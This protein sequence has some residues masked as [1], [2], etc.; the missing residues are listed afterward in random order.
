MA[1]SVSPDNPQHRASISFLF[2]TQSTPSP[3]PAS[4]RLTR[5]VRAPPYM[6]P[7]ALILPPRHPR[8][9]PCWRLPPQALLRPRRPPPPPANCFSTLPPVKRPHT[10][11]RSLPRCI[12]VHCG[13]CCRRLCSSCRCRSSDSRLWTLVVA[14]CACARSSRWTGVLRDDAI[15][16]RD[17]RKDST[18]SAAER[19][20]VARQGGRVDFACYKC[21]PVGQ[22]VKK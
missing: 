5:T 18:G 13:C 17:A 21:R 1:H 16:A 9:L 12:I 2:D 15:L 6:L 8:L 7:C 4:S 11:V 20:H 3:C 22:S 10:M 14:R 19:A